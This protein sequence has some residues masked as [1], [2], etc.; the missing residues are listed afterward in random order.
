MR[1]YLSRFLV[2]CIPWLYR[3][4]KLNFM[5]C[6]PGGCGFFGIRDLHSLDGSACFILLKGSLTIKFFHQLKFSKFVWA[7]ECV[8]SWTF[9]W[10]S[11]IA[12]ISNLDTQTV[13]YFKGVSV[14]PASSIIQYTFA[15]LTVVIRKGQLKTFFP[16]GIENCTQGSQDDCDRY[17]P[18]ACFRSFLSS[19]NLN[20]EN[21]CKT[22]LTWKPGEKQVKK[23]AV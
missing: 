17:K 15:C 13:I 22:F 3:A 6:L 4:C 19:D 10:S 8:F 5:W 7:P 21:L 20:K 9:T 2:V 11:S 1:S 18:L 12:L 14:L 16:L 23:F